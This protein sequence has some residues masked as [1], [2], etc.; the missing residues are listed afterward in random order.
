MKLKTTVLA[1]LVSVGIGIAALPVSAKSVYDASNYKVNAQTARNAIEIAQ[2]EVQQLIQLKES[3]IQLANSTASLGNLPSLAQTSA[4]LKLFNQLKA[5]DSSLLAQVTQAINLNDNLLAQWG[6]TNM[7]FENFCTSIANSAN[8]RD[9]DMVTL[10][11]TS[12]AEMQQAAQ[13]RQ[14]IINKLGNA[15]G[16]TQAI[17]AVGSLVD[18]LIGQNQQVISLMTAKGA[19][20][21]AQKNEEDAQAKYARRVLQNYEARKRSAAAA[22][23]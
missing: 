23:Q 15:V 3:A 5:A 9:R 21:L 12:A 11:E 20:V 14:D 6:A 8:Q 18:V 4:E 22:I 19:D 13:R 16:Q 2:T 17:Q 10:F 7:S 1:V